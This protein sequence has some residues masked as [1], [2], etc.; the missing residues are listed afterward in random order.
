MTLGFRGEALAS[1]CA[2]SKV[3]MI[4]RKADS[5]FGC[6][7]EIAGGEVISKEETGCPVGTTIIVKNLFYNTPA[8]MKFL[9][10]DVS[11]A[12]AVAAVVEKIAVSNPEKNKS[13]AQSP[14]EN[15]KNKINNFNNNN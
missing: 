9:K 11:E 13:A 8:R 3:S 1:V 12:N 7:L 2:V 15:L 10:K 5:D 6:H 4:T 14:L